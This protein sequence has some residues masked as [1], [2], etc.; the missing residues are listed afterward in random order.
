M[1]CCNPANQYNFCLYQG[2]DK[3]MRF[4]YLAAGLPVD[5]TGSDIDFECTVP[6]LNKTGVVRVANG[7][8]AVQSYKVGEYI[9]YTDNLTYVCIENALPNESPTLAPEK[10]AE[11]AIGEFDVIFTPEDTTDVVE[12]IVKYRVVHWPSGYGGVKYTIFTGRINIV[13]EEIV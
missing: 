6:S 12:R 13:P 1:A 2:D 11:Q 7:Y 3:T 10:W 9:L 4:R 8:Q 5:I